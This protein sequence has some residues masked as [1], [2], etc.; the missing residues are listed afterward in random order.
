M[1]KKLF[2][3]VAMLMSWAVCAR[4]QQM[5]AAVNTFMDFPA[6]A[7]LAALGGN[8]VSA[9]STDAMSAVGNPALLSTD[10]DK[11]LHLNYSIYMVSSGYGSAAYNFS[12]SG[13][14]GSDLAANG[15]RDV[16]LCKRATSRLPLLA[17]LLPNMA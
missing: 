16:A 12:I 11:L 17:I 2:L 14:E 3:L 15:K 10:F 5:G 13:N 8:N 9:L 6:S 7:H 1:R 4:A